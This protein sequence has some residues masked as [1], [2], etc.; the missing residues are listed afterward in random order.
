MIVLCAFCIY[1]VQKQKQKI[2]ENTT[3]N[4]CKIII[5]KVI[6]IINVNNI[7][8]VVNDSRERAGTGENR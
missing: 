8:N 7:V 4:K 3:K 1:V 5:V 6:K 2:Y